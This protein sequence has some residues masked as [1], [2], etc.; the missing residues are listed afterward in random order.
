VCVR[1]RAAV[2]VACHKRGSS[3]REAIFVGGV[4]L[5]RSG[6]IIVGCPVVV[7]SFSFSLFGGVRLIAEKKW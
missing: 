4:L 1:V 6:Y 2:V 3:C 7:V 5:Q